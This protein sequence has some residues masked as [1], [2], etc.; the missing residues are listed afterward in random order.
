M[1]TVSTTSFASLLIEAEKRS[2]ISRFQMLGMHVW[3]VLRI[4]L[5]NSARNGT[6]LNSPED[7]ARETEILK[8][9]RH[10]IANGRR[11][12]DA[13]DASH[14]PRWERLWR[15]NWHIER[16]SAWLPSRS[17]GA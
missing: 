8:Q 10:Q 4:L 17:S 16:I 5:I 1:R 9:M 15:D 6:Y 3:P 11:A 14:L 13:F 12:S 7:R 2:N